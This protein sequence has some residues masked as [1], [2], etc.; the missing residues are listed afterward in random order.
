MRRMIAIG[1]CML[2]CLFLLSGCSN[3]KGSDPNPDLS[4]AVEFHIDAEG[5]GDI[6]ISSADNGIVYDFKDPS[7]ADGIVVTPRE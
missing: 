1:A 5:K 4:N 7:N 6:D 3:S 2:V